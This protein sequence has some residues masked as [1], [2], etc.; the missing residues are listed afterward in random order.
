MTAAHAG[1]NLTKPHLDR[2]C[3]YNRLV[4]NDHWWPSVRPVL[5]QFFDDCTVCRSEPACTMRG[6]VAQDMTPHNTVQVT[7]FG[8]FTDM[9]EQVLSCASPTLSLFTFISK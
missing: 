3:S 9:G 2:Q 8:P 5:N 1:R 4:A 6:P 7:I